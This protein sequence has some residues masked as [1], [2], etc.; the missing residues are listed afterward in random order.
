MKRIESLQNPFIKNILK[1][2]EKSRERNKQGLFIIEGKREVELAI[3]GNYEITTLL[4]VS[5]FIKLSFLKQLP[6]LESIEV[7]KEIY[8]KIAYRK[9]TEGIIAIAKTKN[10]HVSSIKLSKNP[11][12]LVA[13]NIEKPGNIGAML[14]TAD[15]AKIDAVIL[16]NP[17]T[18]IY[19]PNII[20]SSIGCV[21]TNQIA[22]GTPEEIIQ[23]LKS[24]KINIFSATLQNSNPYTKENY[25]H[26]TAIVVGSEAN[27][28]TEIWRNNATKNINIPME[29]II[30]SMNVSVSAAI[31]LFEAKRQ[32]IEIDI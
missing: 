19:N 6:K 21:F 18:D 29:G 28:L 31:L 9:T 14:R 30:D 26:A 3:S 23:F 2:Q 5:E 16:V 1:L 17:T 15:A 20:R 24:S 7:S 12:I 10:H 25:K 13:E 32:R 4:F 8:N 27:G 11:L 22:I